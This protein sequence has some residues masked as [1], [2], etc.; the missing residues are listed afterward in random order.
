MGMPLS[1]R[2]AVIYR[3]AHGPG[4]FFGLLRAVPF[5]LGACSVSGESDVAEGFSADGRLVG[6]MFHRKRG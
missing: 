3:F 6:E 5:D 4:E 2:R 1:A